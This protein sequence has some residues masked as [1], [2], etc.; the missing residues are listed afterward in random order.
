MLI[1]TAAFI[2]FNRFVIIINVLY[3]DSRT[4]CTRT[5]RRNRESRG[6]WIIACVGCVD[7]RLWLQFFKSL[8]FLYFY[9]GLN[10]LNI[11]YVESNLNFLKTVRA[12]SRGHRS[13]KS[14]LSVDM[15][16]WKLLFLG[17]KRPEPDKSHHQ[18]PSSDDDM[19]DSGISSGEFSLE[20]VCE[21]SCEPPQKLSLSAPP[22]SVQPIDDQRSVL[23]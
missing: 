21:D 6:R 18:H 5:R 19:S 9:H 15:C 7:V 16:L 17:W 12:P 10:D 1:T 11:I 8:I 13:G 23:W 20:N 3:R 2:T 4:F 14:R 22:T